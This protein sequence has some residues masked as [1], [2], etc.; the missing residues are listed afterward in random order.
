MPVYTADFLMSNTDPSK[1]PEPDKPEYAFIGRSNVG[2]SS[3][4]N[5]LTKQKG[6]A[7]IST[8][9]G[10]TRLINHFLINN[11]WF[12]VDLPGYGYARISQKNRTSWEAM[13]NKYLSIRP[14][15][16]CLFVLIDNRLEPQ[17]IDLEFVNV[18]GKA[19]LPITLVFTKSD[20]ISGSLSDKN[21]AA[22]LKKMRETWDE[23]PPSFITSSRTQMGV[24]ELVA[25]IESI[26]PLFDPAY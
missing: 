10:K 9:P 26:N 19:E 3:L 8:T 25:Y 23:V 18:C 1:C 5:A 20:K 7:K 22:F 21:R 16:M 24:E 17:K 6:L 4:I 14:N 12:L 11:T 15:L 2:K 13:I